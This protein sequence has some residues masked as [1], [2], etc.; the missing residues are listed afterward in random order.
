MEFFSVIGK[1]LSAK[2]D[3]WNLN[4]FFILIGS[5]AVS[6][7][8]LFFDW[9]A[10][11]SNNLNLLLW[12]FLYGAMIFGFGNYFFMKSMNYLEAGELMIF[13][14]FEPV[15]SV[16]LASLILSEK[17]MPL[18]IVGFV[19]ILTAIFLIAKTD[20]KYIALEG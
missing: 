8:L 19:F 11:I 3:S 17:L 6:P 2:Y 15:L 13:A 18:Q 7:I 5:I 20:S 14:N 12:V 1:K 10:L 4:F 9:P 16:I